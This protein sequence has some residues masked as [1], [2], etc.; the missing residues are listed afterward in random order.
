[1]LTVELLNRDGGP[2][3]ASCD[4]AEVQ[5][6]L[7]WRHQWQ[8]AVVPGWW[9]CNACGNLAACPECLG[10]ENRHSLSFSPFVVR[11]VRCLDHRPWAA[12]FAAEWWC[13]DNPR[14]RPVPW[15]AKNEILTAWVQ[16]G[17]APGWRDC[18]W[19]L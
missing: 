16:H 2:L 18:L 10:G 8:R 6:G 3:P 5:S 7:V 4:R 12:T 9:I 19:D 14:L 1:M 11:P 17:G 13:M 15:W